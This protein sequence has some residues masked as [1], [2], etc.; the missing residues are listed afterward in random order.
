MTTPHGSVPFLREY[1]YFVL[2]SLFFAISIGVQ[3]KDRSQRREKTQIDQAVSAEDY[4][5]ESD[6]ADFSLENILGIWTTD[7]NGPHADFVIDTAYFM[8][9]DHEQPAE[10]RYEISDDSI[11][12]HLDGFVSK[13]RILGATGKTLVINWKDQ[14]TIKYFR[15]DD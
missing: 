14:G 6:S 11:F 10:Y 3:C 7:T 12:V 13:G 1:H 15:W 8:M 9:V 5:N 4:S 2:L